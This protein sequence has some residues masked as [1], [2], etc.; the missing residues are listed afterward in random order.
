MGFLVRVLKILLVLVL[1]CV[2]V[3]WFAARRGDRGYMAQEVTIDRPAPMVFRWITT[4]DLL[5]RW[6]SDLVKL[7][8]TGPAGPAQPSSVYR[9]DEFIAKRRVVFEVKVIRT[10]P[11]QELE[12]AVNSAVGSTDSY[13]GT[14]HFKLFPN[15]DY[16]KVEFTSQTDFQS[17]GDQIIEPILTYATQKKMQE[18]LT[19]L[20]LMM[21]AEPAMATQ[22][23]VRGRST[24]KRNSRTFAE[25]S[26]DVR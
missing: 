14:A 24:G 17:L 20:K 1:L 7:E 11:N 3:L 6:I 19:R 23:V 12:L 18:D 10:I 4:D 8:K 25:I 26:T 15:G 5:R 13:T 9:I 21:E 16:T 22:V 2:V